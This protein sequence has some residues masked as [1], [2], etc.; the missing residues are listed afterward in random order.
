MIAELPIRLRRLALLPLIRWL[1]EERLRF[2]LPVAVIFILFDSPLWPF[3]FGISRFLQLGKNHKSG[4]I[5]DWEP[6]VN[7]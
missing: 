2:T 1:P 4:N 5:Y 6:S 3:C 7:T